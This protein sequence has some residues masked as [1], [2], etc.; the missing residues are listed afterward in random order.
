MA[1]TLGTVIEPCHEKTCFWGFQSD[2]HKFG[3][4]A[5]E[6]GLRLEISDLG[7]KGIVLSM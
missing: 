3:C 5:T 4:K 2:Q 1:N 7:T 6:D